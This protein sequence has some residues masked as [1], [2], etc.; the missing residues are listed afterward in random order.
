MTPHTSFLPV[1]ELFLKQTQVAS[2]VL[3]YCLT[4][5]KS[6]SYSKFIT[7]L[8]TPAQS[9]SSTV[10]TLSTMVSINEA[11]VNTHLRD[12][13]ET[14]NAWMELKDNYTLL[15][16]ETFIALQNK[17]KSAPKSKANAGASRLRIGAVTAGKPKSTP[18]D[19]N[20][21]VL[22]DRNPSTVTKLVASISNGLYNKHLNE[23]TNK[24][25]D[26]TATEDAEMVIAEGLHAPRS[27]LVKNHMNFT[28]VTLEDIE[29][30]HAD[31]LLVQNKER[32]TYYSRVAIYGGYVCPGDFVYV[33]ASSNVRF[34]QILSLYKHKSSKSA[35]HVRYFCHGTETMLGDVSSAYELF[36]L[37]ECENVI[38]TSLK[39]KCQV[40]FL[41]PGN[42]EPSY[43]PS[44][45]YFYRFWYNP[46]NAKYE[47]VCRHQVSFDFKQDPVKACDSCIAKKV[48]SSYEI[49][50][51][52]EMNSSF[53]FKGH[54]IR[55]NDFVYLIP[56]KLKVESSKV[57][58]PYNIGQVIAISGG[59]EDSDTTSEV[60]D[61]LFTPIQ[62]K[63][64]H[65]YRQSNFQAVKHTAFS[66]TEGAVPID[67][68]QLYFTE[69]IRTQAATLIDGKCT[70]LHRDTILDLNA[71]KREVDSFWF[72]E[73]LFGDI[74]KESTLSSWKL[75]ELDFDECE[76]N[77]ITIGEI[78]SANRAKDFV[79]ANA[80]KIRALD[81]F[82]GCGGLT[83]G[84][85]QTGVIETTHAIEFAPS[86]ALT[87]K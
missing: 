32:Y 50:Q 27:D 57:Q 42:K 40:E 23:V 85:D 84:M 34:G 45:T 21:A 67:E 9:S 83:A 38:L 14:I 46:Y 69:C 13:L 59:K 35:A 41:E 72:S 56:D 7:S 82:A 49:P 78:Q 54:V 81:I 61:Y 18:K 29:F 65:F 20:Q 5:N 17:K 77:E 39:G 33:E 10:S 86:A 68:R 73:C 44:D 37:D 30:N 79:M 4:S 70:V 19:I 15:D 71:Y 80:P 43:L 47:D 31:E 60:N 63:I 2:T 12:T 75:E 28:N 74:R 48:L 52:I 25:A 76:T 51:I 6:D 62:V 87:F 3:R 55:V 26:A 66:T 24:N 16:H 36:M 22:V 1:F 8:S 64:R 53:N 58:R 11:D